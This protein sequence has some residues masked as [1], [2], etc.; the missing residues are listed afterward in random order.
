MNKSELYMKEE[1]ISNWEEKTFGK[2]RDYFEKNEK[3][4]QN[5]YD[6]QKTITDFE[7][8]EPIITLEE[9][10]LYYN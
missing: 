7:E 8:E 3:P 2:R 4:W 6:K 5:G 1:R 10:E 9:L